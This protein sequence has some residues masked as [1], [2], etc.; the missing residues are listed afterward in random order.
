VIVA[1]GILGW[2]LV[3]FFFLAVCAAAKR[4]RT[5]GRPPSRSSG[6]LAPYRHPGGGRLRTPRGRS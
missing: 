6:S 1:M 5:G 3:A 4:G 2:L